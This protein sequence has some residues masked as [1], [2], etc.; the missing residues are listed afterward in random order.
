MYKCMH[1][2]CI[3]SIDQRE[4]KAREMCR[5]GSSTELSED[6]EKQPNRD[7]FQIIKLISN[8]AYR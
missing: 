4:V 6:Q 8:G 3:L 1:V 2:H 7:D 5:R